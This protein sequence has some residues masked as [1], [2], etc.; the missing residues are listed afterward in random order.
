MFNFNARRLPN[1]AAYTLTVNSPTWGCSDYVETLGEVTKVGS[2]WQLHFINDE[3]H[4]DLDTLA[5]YVARE[6]RGNH[7]LHLNLVL[8]AVRK[9]YQQRY[10]DARALQR[11]EDGEEAIERANDAWASQQTEIDARYGM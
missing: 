5:A 8:A 2:R 1:R 3:D 11:A 10:A 9:G 6:L 7:Y 4:G